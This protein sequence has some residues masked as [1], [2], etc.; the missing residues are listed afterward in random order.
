M[1]KL[2]FIAICASIIGLNACS[3]Q[4]KA[5]EERVQARWDAL[6][7]DDITEAYSYISPGYRSSV[8]EQHYRNKLARQAVV[9]VT[10]NYDSHQCEADV[11]NVNV[12]LTYRVTNPLPG[13]KNWESTQQ[14]DEKWIKVKGKWYF[15][16][17]K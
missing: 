15:L 4:P 9:W 12:N 14:V 16:P 5:I 6:F 1:K 7:S 11:C 8:S 10:A 2:F 17:E 3:K 13:V